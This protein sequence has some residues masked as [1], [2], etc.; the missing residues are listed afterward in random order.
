MSKREVNKEMIYIG[1][2]GNWRIVH[3]V[4]ETD[5]SVWVKPRFEGSKPARHQKQ[6]SDG[7]YYEMDDE[8][9]DAALERLNQRFKTM[10]KKASEAFGQWETLNVHINRT[11]QER[12]KEETFDLEPGGNI[13]YDQ[14]P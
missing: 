1:W 13:P 5:V 7:A 14:E 8:G 10:Q 2:T 6:T 4:A 12:T 3:V 9:M 11:R